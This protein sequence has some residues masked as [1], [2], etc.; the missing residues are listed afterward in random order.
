[1][2]AAP[3]LVESVKQLLTERDWRWQVQFHP[4]MPQEVTDLYRAIQCEKLQVVE[5]HETLQLLLDADAMLCDTSSIISEFTLLQK[6][7]VTFRNL[8]PKPFMIDVVNPGQVGEALAQALSRPPDLMR[9][10]EHHARETHPW[11]DGRS[12]ERIV[13]AT[14]RLV[15]SGLG[16]LRPKPRNL[17][18]HWKMRKELDY[19]SL[20]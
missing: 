11:N 14:D 7:V 15:N 19:F 12:S 5:G 4:K 9:H 18:R 10:I 6:P 8:S 1:L 17:I 13:A 2:T 20:A 16:H 3:H